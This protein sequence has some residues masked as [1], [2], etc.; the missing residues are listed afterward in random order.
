MLGLGSLAF[1]IEKE[2]NEG[3]EL[4]SFA[5]RERQTGGRPLGYRVLW[6]ALAFLCASL[7]IAP[8]AGKN[9]ALEAAGQEIARLRPQAEAAGKLRVEREKR[10]ALLTKVARL[11]RTSPVPLLILA[12]LSAAFDDQSFLFDF[13]LQGSSLTISG[14]SGDASLLAQKLGAMPEFK[15][16]KFV[17][18]VTRDPQKPRDRFT[19]ALELAPAS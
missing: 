17:G 7:V 2:G 8:M 18:A 15:S 16:V 1:A 12:K 6:A 9:K 13:R 11:K 19:L 4:L 5:F 10:S 14:V 3:F